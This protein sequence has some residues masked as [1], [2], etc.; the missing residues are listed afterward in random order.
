MMFVVMVRGKV[1]AVVPELV[2]QQLVV[3]PIV[4]RQT[5]VWMTPRIPMASCLMTAVAQWTVLLPPTTVRLLLSWR[6]L[7]RFLCAF[8]YLAHYLLQA[9]LS[10]VGVLHHQHHRPTRQYRVVVV[11]QV[12]VLQQPLLSSH[13]TH[14]PPTLPSAPLPSMSTGRPHVRNL[15]C[16]HPQPPRCQ[17][18]SEAVS[19]GT[20]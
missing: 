19:M 12:Q 2:V 14:P 8:P 11:V 6:P 4:L 10:H 3:Q 16:A 1:S 13:R 20:T 18:S 5:I 17:V 7:L 9:Q 15:F